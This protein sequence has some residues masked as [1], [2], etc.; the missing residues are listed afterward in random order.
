MEINSNIHTLGFSTL[1]S[2]MVFKRWIEIKGTLSVPALAGVSKGQCIGTGLQGPKADTSLCK[3][4]LILIIFLIGLWI[5]Q[6][7]SSCCRELK[8]LSYE[9]PL[10]SGWSS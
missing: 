7:H 6:D 10:V 1:K 8:E 9:F 3:G 5:L 2:Y 4:N